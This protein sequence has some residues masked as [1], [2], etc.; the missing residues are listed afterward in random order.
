MEDSSFSHFKNTFMISCNNRF[1]FFVKSD[2]S[3]PLIILYFMKIAIHSCAGLSSTSSTTNV[4]GISLFTALALN[5]YSFDVVSGKGGIKA[6]LLYFIPQP[7]YKLSCSLCEENETAPGQIFDRI[8]TIDVFGK[9]SCMRRTVH[10]GMK[11]EEFSEH[12]GVPDIRY[13]FHE[14]KSSNFADS[15][16]V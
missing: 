3:R 5:L 2:F 8:R 12:N 16:E 6:L 14:D 9:C 7:L 11:L 13:R 4:P 15:T 1:I 10:I